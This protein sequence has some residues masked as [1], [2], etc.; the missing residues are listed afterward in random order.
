MKRTLASRLN[1]ATVHVGRAL[2]AGADTHGLAAEQ[3]S[4]LSVTYF[5]GPLRMGALAAAERVR[6]PS[7]TR[8][9]LIPWAAGLERLGRYPNNALAVLAPITLTGSV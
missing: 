5:A 1:S 2:R 3:P 7:Q 4:A 9:V 6:A 8:T